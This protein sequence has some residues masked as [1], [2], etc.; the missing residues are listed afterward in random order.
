LCRGTGLCYNKPMDTI[1]QQ[2]VKALKEIFSFALRFLKQGDFD[3]ARQAFEIVIKESEDKE[4]KG[5]LSK[6]F[7]M[8]SLREKTERYLKEIPLRQA[9]AEEKRRADAPRRAKVEDERRK[10]A[11]ERQKKEEER[12]RR[13]TKDRREEEKKMPQKPQEKTEPREKKVQTKRYLRQEEL[14]LIFQKALDCY[15]KN[16]IEVA[17]K[18]SEILLKE[19]E[20]EKDRAGFIKRLFVIGPLARKTKGILDKIE[21]KKREEE[22]RKRQVQKLKEIEEVIR[23][24]REDIKKPE[25]I[26]KQ[27]E[28]LVKKYE[29][30]LKIQK[31]K[32]SEKYE[33]ELE[34]Q[35][36]ELLQ[37]QK[38]LRREER[39]LGE[40]E[41]GLEER[42]AEIKEKYEQ[43]LERAKKALEEQQ[44]E[45]VKELAG[46][47]ETKKRQEALIKEEEELK[48][49]EEEAKKMRKE[50]TEVL[51]EEERA[52]REETISMAEEEIK[53]KRKMIEEE[54]KRIE[55]EEIEKR[56]LEEK[57]KETA[58]VKET[59]A[60]KEKRLIW[61]KETIR[62]EKEMMAPEEM[63][64]E[65]KERAANLKMLFEEAIF[66]YK[67]KNLRTAI[68]I[69]QTLKKELPEPEKEPGFFSKLLG[70]VPLYIRIEDYI[71]K[72]RREEAIEEKKE[73]KEIREKA[74]IL[75]GEKK[76]EEYRPPSRLKKIVNK[77]ILPS[78]FVI[79]KKFLFLPPLVA[80]DVSDYSIEL[81]RLNKSFSILAYGRSIIKEGVV[82]EGE[83]KDPKE[84][85]LA[86]K[87]TINQAGFKPFRPRQGPILRGIV[88]VPEYKT[89]VQTFTFDSKDNIF[90]KVKEELKKTVP[91]S[92]DEL[93]WNYIEKWDEKLNK[94]KVLA[95][96]V[97]KD[98]I[99]EQIYFLKSFGVEPVVFDI[100]A[101]SIGRA[102]LS[103]EVTPAKS[104]TLILDIGAR[105]TNINIFDETG[106]I[107]LSTA[108]PSAGNCLVDKIV[109]YFD[110]SRE[111]AE[112]IMNIKGFRQEDNAILEVLEKRMERIVEETEEAIKH[113]QKKTE[114]EIKKII[115]SG[116]TT[117]L[118]EIDKFFQR[119][120]QNIK[121]EIGDPLRKI[122]RR[123]GIDPV[124]AVLY[125]NSIG[126][127]LRSII[128]DPIGEGINF[129]PGK[130]K[131]KE[132]KVY[133]QRHRQKLIIIEVVLAILILAA[134]ALIY[135]YI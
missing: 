40:L 27:K 1:R 112:M 30:E 39:R 19:I 78:P 87:L 17:A 62:K 100:E 5:F 51:S 105:V 15:S 26:E 81:L 44:T 113:Y 83:I 18:L 54:T 11:E 85:S 34:R 63:K 24:Q 25:E 10:K 68:E 82:S 21:R 96:A 108:I 9:R 59:E 55:Q 70:K 56:Q 36:D 60:E 132:K 135:L 110:I 93:Y 101:A 66:H 37:K 61:L 104:S 48:S 131:E 43:E 35:M 106:F 47:E 72:I 118:P 42:K 20:D 115:L 89:N 117:L 16:E 28:E 125:A 95:V 69:F 111:E 134:A 7:G 46:V 49:R 114:N 73:I 3:I 77:L 22:A 99:D 64:R 74:R 79:L 91:L 41:K 109:E 119:R 58:G 122:K 120:F 121:I 52:K 57:G 94:T 97:L 33:K 90:E 98:I 31:E 67:E 123:G 128:R 102:L 14:Q 50:P 12:I 32:I 76:E 88:S 126:L 103:E 45:E 84:L 6:I 75:S 29:E 23:K 92:I 86:F 129:L 80:V 13:E 124:K 2:R 71:S 65:E 4:K 133:W 38:E 116:G 107:D 53:E 130:I 127:A 8:P